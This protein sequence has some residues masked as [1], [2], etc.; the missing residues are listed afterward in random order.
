MSHLVAEKKDSI[1]HL[2]HH[3]TSGDAPVGRCCTGDVSKLGVMTF[4][5]VV[6]AL[7]SEA[8]GK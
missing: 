6:T 4:F 2:A 8:G 7:A 1:G 3:A 5:L